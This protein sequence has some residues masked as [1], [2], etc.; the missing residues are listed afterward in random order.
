MIVVADTSPINYLILIEQIDILRRLYGRVLVPEGVTAELAAQ[1]ARP[2]VRA[3]VA[4]PP[5]WFEVRPVDV[6]AG[7]G[8]DGVDSGEAQAIVLAAS[9]GPGALLLIDDLD[10]RRAA[11]ERG[12]AT[13]GTLGVL[14]SAAQNNLLDV[15]EAVDR[16][17]RTNFR[18]SPDL[19]H[20]LL[21]LDRRRRQR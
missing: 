14:N 6:P 20:D 8:L 12:I 2:S 1:R 9:V 21:E 10:G 3:W 18:V 16:L 11:A 4:R 17:T 15:R 7:S 19:I 13:T 5:D